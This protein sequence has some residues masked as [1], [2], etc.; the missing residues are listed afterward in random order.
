MRGG[1]EDWPCH[2]IRRTYSGCSGE[3]VDPFGAR[4][5]TSQLFGFMLI[6]MEYDNLGLETL[7]V[8]Q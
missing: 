6:G 1:A 4:A 5:K 8:L 3:A 7:A 2:P